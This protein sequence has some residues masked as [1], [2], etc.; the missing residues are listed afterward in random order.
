MLSLASL[1]SSS[2]AKP[3]LKPA[4]TARHAFARLS[5]HCA[6]RSLSRMRSARR[7]RRA[8][9]SPACIDGTVRPSKPYDYD[10]AGSASY[11]CP[12]PYTCEYARSVSALACRAPID[13][14]LRRSVWFIAPNSIGNFSPLKMPALDTSLTYRPPSP[15]RGQLGQ[16]GVYA[17]ATVDRTTGARTL[18]TGSDG[19]LIYAPRDYNAAANVAAADGSWNP[20]WFR[21][22]VQNGGPWDYKQQDPALFEHL[23]NF[24]YG[25]TGAAWGFP[26]RVL[27]R[28]AGDA[29]VDAGTSNPAFGRPGVTPLGIGATGS[30]G[31][32]PRDQ[33]DIRAGIN[34]HDSGARITVVMVGVYGPVR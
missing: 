4:G 30:F 29:Q 22:Q 7:P 14:Q 1:K 34:A 26:D 33:A 13:L 19:V 15:G 12:A 5:S 11:P 16:L 18:L 23:G 24:N 9:P 8:T 17:L 28:Q 20:F 6:A 21:R 3:P 31:D 32:D 10:H 25:L 27:L 2:V